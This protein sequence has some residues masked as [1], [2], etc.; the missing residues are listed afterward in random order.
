MLNPD[1]LVVQWQD[2]CLVAAVRYCPGLLLLAIAPATG[3]LG[4]ALPLPYLA[5]IGVTI[6]S[7]LTPIPS[8][9]NAHVI[10]AHAD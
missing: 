4:T 10:A 6:V 1:L 5:A 8:Q 7:S 2:V 3:T 9:V